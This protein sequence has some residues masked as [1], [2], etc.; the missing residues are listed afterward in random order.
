MINAAEAITVKQE[1][2]NKKLTVSNMN[3]NAVSRDS[4]EQFLKGW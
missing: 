2:G 4:R 3:D 1:Q